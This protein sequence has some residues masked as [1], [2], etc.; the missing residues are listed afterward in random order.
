M[1]LTSIFLSLFLHIL[2]LFQRLCALCSSTC[3][4]HYIIGTVLFQR[5]LS[6]PHVCLTYSYVFFIFTN[7]SLYFSHWSKCLLYLLPFAFTH[8]Y[9]SYT[10][11]Y[12]FF[13]CFF[14]ISTCVFIR[15]LFII[16]FLQEWGQL[17]DKKKGVIHEKGPLK[18]LFHIRD[19]LDLPSPFC[20]F[21]LPISILS[22]F[23][24][25]FPKSFFTS[26]RVSFIL[27]SARHSALTR[28]SSLLGFK[29]SLW[30]INAPAI[31]RV[32]MFW[33]CEKVKERMGKE[34]AE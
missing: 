32:S 33:R 20:F 1:L 12:S 4:S 2:A 30:E 19:E 6:C 3:R 25:I 26:T 10:S 9:F 23:S 5:S 34:K 27:L 18:A 16:I 24:L 7:V 11:T 13:L 28:P 31:N 22:F 29:G 21:F 15:I 8:S 14:S 17:K